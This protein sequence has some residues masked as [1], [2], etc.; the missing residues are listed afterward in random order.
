MYKA[1]F[2]FWNSSG[3]RCCINCCV[4]S[5]NL[6]VIWSIFNVHHHR[7]IM[8]WASDPMRSIGPFGSAVMEQT[9]FIDLQLRLGQPYVYMHQGDCEHLIVFSDM[10]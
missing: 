10:R 6:C 5:V 3:K 4:K 7:H 1:Q 9:R 2:S 8:D